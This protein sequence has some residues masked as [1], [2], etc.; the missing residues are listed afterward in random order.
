MNKTFRFKPSFHK[1]N[2][3]Q[4]E[5]RVLKGLKQGEI[6]ALISDAGTPGI[7]DIAL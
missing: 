7:S 5:Q 2:E 3:S 6:I 1:F 4:G